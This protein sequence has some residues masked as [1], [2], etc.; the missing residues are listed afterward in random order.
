MKKVS[1]YCL[2]IL[3][4]LFVLVPPTPSKDESPVKDMN[5]KTLGVDY[6]YI[7]CLASNRIVDRYIPVS[8]F[9]K[10]LGKGMGKLGDFEVTYTGF[11]PEAQAA[12]QFAVDIWDMLLDS[13]AKI[14]VDANFSDLNSGVLGAA[15]PTALYANFSDRVDPNIEFAA[16]LAEKI[17]GHSLNKTAADLRC[18]FN[19]STN[20][21]YDFNNVHEIA[22][23]QYDFTSVVLHELGHGL[24]FLSSNTF[25]STAGIGFIGAEAPLTTDIFSL[26]LENGGGVNLA[27][28]FEDGSTDLGRVLTSRDVYLHSHTVPNDPLP[29]IFAPAPWS[30]GSSLSHLDESSFNITDP[31]M[32]PSIGSMEVIHDPGV[33]LTLMN[34][35][36]WRSSFIEHRAHNQ[37][38][39][40]E[41]LPISAQVFT[42]EGVGFDSSSVLLI[43]SQDS[44]RLS[45]DTLVLTSADASSTFTVELPADNNTGRYQYYIA[46]V[47]TINKGYSSPLL[48]PARFHDVQIGIDDVAPTISHAP[49]EF[50]FLN[51]DQPLINP[52]VIDGFTGV[53]TVMVEYKINGEAI[54]TIGLDHKEF[55]LYEQFLDI[56]PAVL[57]EGDIIEYRIKATDNAMSSNSGTLP[58]E[59]YFVITIKD[60]PDVLNYYFTDFEDTN[61]DFSYESFSISAHAGFD[62]LALHTDHPYTNAGTG[63]ELNL[64]SG[65]RVPIRIVNEGT[66]EF[67]EVVLVEP[68]E[69]SN[70][71]GDSQFWDYVI[72]EASKNNGASWI[73]L[74]DGYDSTDR[75]IWKNRY[76]AGVDGQNSTSSADKNLLVRRT[77]PLHQPALGL[78][79]GDVVILRWRL[80]SDPFAVGWGWMIDNLEIQ[81]TQNT[82]PVIVIDEH[83]EDIKIY[84]NPTFIDQLQFTSVGDIKVKKVF[85]SDSSGR[86]IGNHIFPQRQNGQYDIDISTLSSGV[87]FVLFETDDIWISKRFLKL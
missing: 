75:T 23:N 21:F 74:A 9:T 52:E 50:F 27:L 46:L 85:I 41:P 40:D 26:L 28:N 16:P 62:G 36:G 65:L 77:I 81:K 86:R 37:E 4:I 82:T 29:K 34:D 22:A 45:I 83:S 42:D 63:N 15:A 43:Y 8:D 48:A 3:I 19:S 66:I 64:V 70:D 56:D 31:L 69:P 14:V 59:G 71:F 1:L 76:D 58:T 49:V 39:M 24:G 18:S 44:F 57:S 17:A 79:V 53:D 2:L 33:A 60:V 20:W 68:A 35:M 7:Y 87:Y 61:I 73:A 80:F 30:S 5:V 25:A 78:N 11:T 67:D 12:F 51:E 55:N 47:D 6:D 13:D 54:I 32:T 10:L 72:V 38:L 84:P